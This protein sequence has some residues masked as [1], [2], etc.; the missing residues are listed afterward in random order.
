MSPLTLIIISTVLVSLISLIGIAAL[1]LKEKILEKI[2][3]ALVGLSAGAL[4]GGAFIHLLPEAA[5]LAS[6]NKIS[7]Y[8]LIGFILFFI[9]EKILHWRHCHKVKCEIHTFAYMNMLGDGIHNFVDGLII[10]ASYIVSI[11]LGIATT[12]A[13]ALHEIPQEIGDFGVLVYGGYTKAKALAL[14]FAFAL[15]AVLGGIAGYALSGIID[16]TT[17]FLLPFAAGGFIYIS[18]SDLLP[19][20]KKEKSLKKSMLSLLVFLIGIILMFSIRLVH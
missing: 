18:A 20:I 16:N 19:E 15:T 1:T 13:V 14:N 7:V 4:L 5:E 2:L 12:I 17:S 9:I 8:V 3:L 6:Q 11:P 10:A